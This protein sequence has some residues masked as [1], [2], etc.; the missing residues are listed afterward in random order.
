VNDRSSLGSIRQQRL[1]NLLRKIRIYA[2]YSRAREVGRLLLG[3]VFI[4]LVALGGGTHAWDAETHRDLA[5][6]H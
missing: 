4:N 1:N 6:V 3:A 5:A 2:I